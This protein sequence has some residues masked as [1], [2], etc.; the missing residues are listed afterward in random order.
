[1]RRVSSLLAFAQDIEDRKRS[2]GITDDVIR[3]ARNDGER[4]TPAKREML[5]TMRERALD[6]GL[7]PMAANF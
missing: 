5:A 7:E 3:L 4:R 6:R 1:M 2:I